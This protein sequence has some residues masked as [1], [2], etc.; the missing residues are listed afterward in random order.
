MPVDSQALIESAKLA[1]QNASC[2]ADWRGVCARA[3][4]AIYQDGDAFHKSLPKP[5]SL[6]PDSRGG[7]HENLA[8]QLQNPTISKTD[9]LYGKSRK[10]GYLMASL[11]STRVK[12]DYYR[13]KSLSKQECETS[14]A[15]LAEVNVLLTGNSV[16]SS[17]PV[18]VAKSADASCTND[19]RSAE[20][21]DRRRPTL[22]RIR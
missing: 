20:T 7:T 6:R 15:Q 14:M 10:V 9:P 3:Y 13:D 5:G 19:R 1:H 2:E 21:P 12:A 18:P 16:A 17:N 11:H 4:Y 8:Q 22:T